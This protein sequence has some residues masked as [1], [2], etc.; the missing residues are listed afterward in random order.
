MARLPIL[1]YHNVSPNGGL[2]DGLTIAADRLEEQLQ[3]LQS[4]GYKALH[5]SDIEGKNDL[6]EKAIVITFDDVT[7]NQLDHAVPLLEKYKMKAVF[8][9]PFKYLGKTDEWN[10][11]AEPIMDATQLKSLPPIIELGYHSYAHRHYTTLTEEEVNADFARCQNVI[12]ENGLNV[13]EAVAYP[14]GNFPKKG[15]AN[16]EFRQWLQN[17]GMK[18]GLRIGNRVNNFPF[19]DEYAIQ[20]IDV[21]GQYSLKSFKWR[22]RFGR[23]KLF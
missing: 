2:S 6:P 21:K 15:V 7:V 12:A 17:N 5:L 9:I 20:R 4:A 3:W 18:M 22:V 8:F 19:R 23:L 13:Y 1:M 11:G 10:D 14:Y 16:R